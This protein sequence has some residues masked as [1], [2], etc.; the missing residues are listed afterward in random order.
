MTNALAGRVAVITAS[1]RGMGR[2]IAEHF[3]A[4]G[5]S[6]VVSGR[7]E[8]SGAKALAELGA[9]DRA[10]AFPCDARDQA[11]VEALIDSAA[12]H[13]GRLDI[14][15]NCAGG[16]DGF[17][18]IHEMT[19]E[20]WHNAMDFVLNSAFWGTRR[21]LP[22]MLANGFGRIINISSI[23]GKQGNKPNVAHY[24]TA[25]HALN[26]L[27]KATAFE[28]GKQGV[29]CNAIC[30]GA[31]ETDT[32]QELGGAYAAQAGLSYD[33]FK[34]M[35]TDETPLGRLNT[36]EEVA[37]L[38]VLLAS[39]PGGGINGSLINVDGGAVPF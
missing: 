23:E 6:V 4:E 25:K 10:A 29:T 9:G 1:S 7:T 19:D 16:S 22:H 11:Q 17:A 33:A 27:T 34:Q 30:P 18:L 38:A 36:V 21:A 32:F 14:L 12:A 5:A 28:Y 13:F 35:Y 8:E 20:A 3:L 39:E 37:A 24:I 2:G 26:G 31:V 15:V